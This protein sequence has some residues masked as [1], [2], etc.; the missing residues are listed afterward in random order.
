MKTARVQFCILIGA[1]ALVA[2][3]GNDQ[4]PRIELIPADTAG[5]E[6]RPPEYIERQARPMTREEAEALGIIDTTIQV[7]DEP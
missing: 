2:C 3:N 1:V 4:A 6:A 5:V 7:N